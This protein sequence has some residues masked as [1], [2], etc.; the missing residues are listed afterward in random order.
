ML[1]NASPEASRC[2][3]MAELSDY[4][5]QTQS[6]ARKLGFVSPE[7]G[8]VFFDHVPFSNLVTILIMDKPI[9]GRV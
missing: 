7:R 8:L 3:G 9:D 6:P 5:T 4:W 2:Y 1:Y